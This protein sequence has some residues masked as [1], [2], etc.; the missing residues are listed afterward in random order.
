[1]ELTSEL[2]EKAYFDIHDE[3]VD[4]SESHLEEV[5]MAMENESNF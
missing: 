5:N 3:N 1:M 4:L 2:E